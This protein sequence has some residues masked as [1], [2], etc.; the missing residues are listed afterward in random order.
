MANLDNGVMLGALGNSAR[1]TAGSL[2]PPSGM[3]IAAIQFAGKAT[4]SALTA[5]DNDKWINV[6]HAAN[7]LG[8]GSETG[9]S[10]TTETEG[11]GGEDLGNAQVFAAGITIYG[12]WTSLTVTDPV[13]GPVIAYFGY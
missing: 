5:E 13:N 1:I 8:A 6:D 3:V 9:A 4:L 11:S 12:R 10:S 7:S 2:A